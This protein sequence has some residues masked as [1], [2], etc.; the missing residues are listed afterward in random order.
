MLDMKKL[1]CLLLVAVVALSLISCNKDVVVSFD[2]ATQEID[3]QGGPVEVALKSNGEWTVGSSAEWL[4]VTPTSGN[5]DATLTLTADA[6]TF[7]ETRTA[8]ITATTKDKTAVMTVTQQAPEYYINVTPKEI[9]CDG[10][11]GEYVVQVSSNIEWMVSTPHWITSSVTQGSDDATV[12]LTVAVVDGD[13]GTLRDAQVFFGNLV[14]SDK[15]HV[16]QSIA[17]IMSI[18]VTPPS[19][20]YVCTGETKTV[21]VTTEDTW[22]A[23][24]TEDWIGLSQT[25]GQGDAVVNV[26][27]G[28]NPVYV[29]RQAVV[30]FVTAGEI[31]AT[32]VVRQ[33]ASPDPHFLEVSP[34]LFHFGKEGGE[35]EISIECD[36]DWLFD[37]ECDWLSVS[38]PT[39]TGNATVTLFAEPNAIMEPRAFG[40][41]IKSGALSY[42]LEVTQEA[43]T[44]TVFAEFTTDTVFAVATGGLLHL[45]LTSNTLWSLVASDWISLITSSGV[46]D[47]SFDIVVN[48]N[49]NS[50][51]RIGYVNIMHGGQLLDAVVVVQEGHQDILEVDITELDVR[52]EGGEFTVHVTA[53]QSWA[54]NIDVDWVHCDMMSGFG[55]KDVVITVDEMSGVRPRTGRIKFGG[56]SGSEVT[57]TVNQH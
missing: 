39:G 1:K 29:S 34:L 21:S 54:V 55:N 28:E 12:T 49:S 18:E 41:G 46:G 10:D 5:G 26:T 50:E 52:P 47:A 17:P 51:P 15:V 9:T 37:L 20:D 33:E 2:A 27:V 23:T 40:F 25:E 38:Q 14:V 3:A 32:V 11:G 57:V 16:V 19:L 4:V 56:S 53:N 36:T 24:A 42:E 7:N 13:I 22:T 45:E 35:A 6:N 43:G 48:S 30:T 8:E 44:E 31:H